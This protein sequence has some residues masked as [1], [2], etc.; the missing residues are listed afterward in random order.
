MEANNP[1]LIK[2]LSQHLP[3]GTEANCEELLSVYTM[4]LPRLEPRTSKIQVESMLHPC[5]KL[6]PSFS[7]TCPNTY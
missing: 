5:C 7:K 3:G 2:I 6:Y 1:G 4:F